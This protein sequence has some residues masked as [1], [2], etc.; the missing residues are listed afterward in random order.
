MDLDKKSCSPFSHSSL[1]NQC[2][3]L[4]LAFKDD[5]RSGRSRRLELEKVRSI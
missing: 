5:F 1:R 2:K 4:D 3:N